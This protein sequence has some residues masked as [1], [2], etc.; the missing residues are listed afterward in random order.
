LALATS[1]R[2]GDLTG[3]TGTTN[4]RKAIVVGA[5]VAGLTAA[6][7]LEE[8]GWEVQVVE[9]RRRT[10]GRVYTVASPFANR[11]H[12]E[13]GGEFI[14]TKHRFLRAYARRFDL[15]LE[16]V[17]RGYGRLDDVAFRRGR[18][19]SYVR[20]GT[21]G[22]RQLDRFWSRLTSLAEPID[23]LEPSRTGAR[24][25]TKSVLELIEE[26]GVSGRARGVL[27]RD[28]EDDYGVDP[29]S[30]SLL[31]AATAERAAWDQGEAGIE[32]FRIEGGNSRL[33]RAMARSLEHPVLY[34]A[35]VASVRQD[36]GGVEVTTDDGLAFT[37]DVVVCALPLPAMRAISFTPQLQT[38]KR[39]AIRSL[40]Y[41]PIGKT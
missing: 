41:A 33:P 5:G 4:A 22:R 36:P 10:G 39:E 29:R 20:L 27:V 40:D 18:R 31:M 21:R 34:G 17:Y 30:I 16:V 11:Q 35:R 14:D 2:L 25:D 23:P 13:A 19:R 6:I 24:L 38:G 7:E 37:G 9:A 3:Q 8:R 28:F 15:P 12:A 1:H 32:R 26:V